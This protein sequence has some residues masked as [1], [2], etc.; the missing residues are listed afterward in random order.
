MSPQSAQKEEVLGSLLLQVSGVSSLAEILR[1]VG[2][3][4]LEDVV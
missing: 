3:Q 1:N 4:E 2:P